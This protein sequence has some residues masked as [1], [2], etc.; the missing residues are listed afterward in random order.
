MYDLLFDNW[1]GVF[2][3]AIKSTFA[4]FFMV[5]ILKLSGKRTLTKMNP[6]DSTVI[7][8]YGSIVAAI[9]IDKNVKILE[10]LIAMI[11]LIFL[12]YL[13]T[14][15]SKKHAA[16]RRMIRSKPSL[17]IFNGKYIES[18]LRTERLCML[19][20]ESILKSQGITQLS[21]VGAA[22]L[23]GNGQ[24]TILPKTPD[25]ENQKEQTLDLRA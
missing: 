24:V 15:W 2:A 5:L 12:Q 4:F 19:E 1:K 13:V 10:G 20:M 22:V 8:A 14:S 23:E 3:V 25:F 16:F 11:A 7:Y 9:S 21:E 17:L 6:F 18:A